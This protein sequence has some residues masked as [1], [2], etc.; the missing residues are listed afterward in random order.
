MEVKWVDANKGDKEKAEYRCMLVAKET[1]KD[2]RE[3]LFAA[4]PPLEAKKMLFSLCASVPRMC[5][6][7]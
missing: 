1:K 4:P 6:D 3:D 2:K 5:L 7:F